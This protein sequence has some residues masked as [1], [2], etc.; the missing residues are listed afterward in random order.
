MMA[1]CKTYS[2]SKEGP[3]GSND[4]FTLAVEEGMRCPRGVQYIFGDSVNAVFRWRGKFPGM[5]T[6]RK[7]LP[8]HRRRP[9][10]LTNN[11]SH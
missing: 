1:K 9:S 4:K 11:H 5:R 10:T 2:K 3:N 8:N 6:S 7:N